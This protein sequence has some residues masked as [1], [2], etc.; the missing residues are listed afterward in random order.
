MARRSEAIGSCSRISPL[1]TPDLRRRRYRRPSW[2]RHGRNQHRRAACAAERDPRGTIPC[3]AISAPPRRPEQ[4]MRMP[5]APRRMADCTARFM[6][7]RKAMRRSSCCAIDW[8][9][10]VASIFRLADLDDVEVRIDLRHIRQ[11]SCE[12]SQMSAPLL[13]DDEA[14]TRR[15]NGH[16]ALSCA[17]ARSRSWRRPP[18][19]S[20]FS[21]NSRIFR[22]SCRSLPYSPVLANQRESQVRLMPSR[23]TDWIDFLAHQAASTS[24]SSRDDDGQMRKTASRCG[25]ERPRPRAW[26]PLHD[27]RLADIG[28]GHNERIHVQAVVVLGIGDCRFPASFLT[29]LAIRLRE[30]SR[31]VSA[32]ATGLPRIH[33]GKPRLSFCGLTRS[34]R[35]NRTCLVVRKPARSLGLAH[36][37]L[38]LRLLVRAT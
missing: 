29:V 20:S 6:A 17:G 33:G 36:E 31:S 16:A 15:M 25:L 22:S 19:C 2:L 9:I 28:L 5:S 27:D 12:A 24:S 18:A 7:R 34:V 14:R 13:A 32:L 26:E 21:R 10:S 11:L 37:L 3:A 23:R 35:G 4:L 30:N 8:A 38:P 1:K